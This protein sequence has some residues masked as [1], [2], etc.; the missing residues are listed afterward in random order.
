MPGIRALPS[1]NCDERPEGSPIDM[2]VLHY[3][4]MPS[5]RD[6]IER[7]RD[8]SPPTGVRVSSH[9]VVDEDGHILHLVPEEKRA[10]HAGLSYWRGMT[11][12]NDR[13]LGIEIV[14]PGHEFGYHA[15]PVLQLSALCD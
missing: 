11:E 12:L 7:L 4:G 14:N 13:S 15:F 8:L 3:T 9:Y 5:A 1:P 10:W 6:A 2:L